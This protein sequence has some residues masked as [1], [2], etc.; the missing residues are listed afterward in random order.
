MHHAGVSPDGVACGTGHRN[1]RA[2]VVVSESPGL[3]IYIIYI[4][5]C[6]KH[7]KKQALSLQVFSTTMS[8]AQ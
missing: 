6:Q 7:L 8:E 4:V 2:E 1:I 5:E 3:F